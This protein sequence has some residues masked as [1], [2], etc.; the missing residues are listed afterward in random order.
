MLFLRS[1]GSYSDEGP[2][3][4]AEDGRLRFIG[5]EVLRALKYKPHAL[6]MVEPVGDLLQRGVLLVPQLL[7]K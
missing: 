4:F 5:L 6:Q 7:L 3:A 2:E 1:D